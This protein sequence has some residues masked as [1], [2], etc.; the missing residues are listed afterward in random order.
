MDDIKNTIREFIVRDYLPGESPASLRDETRLQSSGILDSLMLLGL[1]NFLER[2][3]DIELSVYDTGVE[4]F[5]RLG[6]IARLV[7]RKRSRA[8]GVTQS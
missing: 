3:F 8:D 4:S 7:A 6:D 2:E 5:D 1:I